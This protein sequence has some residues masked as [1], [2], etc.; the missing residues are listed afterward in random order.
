[1]E[2]ATRRSDDEPVTERE[3]TITREYDVPARVLFAACSQPEHVIQWFGPKG[4]PLTLCEIDFRVGGT[5]RFQMTGPDGEKGPPFGGEYLAIEQDRRI[6]FSNGFLLPGAERM[7][8]TWSFEEHGGKTTFRHH[9]VFSSAAMK[10]EHLGLGFDG[11]V[12]SGLDQL[13][14]VVARLAAQ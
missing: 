8:V 1:M 9:T 5:F 4:Y 2:Q 6:Q 12:N 14:D 7:L 13:T 3:H 10:K 11:G